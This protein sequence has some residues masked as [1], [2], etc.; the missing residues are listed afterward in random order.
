[1]RG[2][3]SGDWVVLES[4]ADAEE[5]RLIEGFLHSEGIDCEIESLRFNQEPVNLG[6]LSEIRLR[7]PETQIAEARAA[8]ER[9]RRETLDDL[10]ESDDD[11]PR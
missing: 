3:D 5:A 2:S 1:M 6:R 11:G 8:L 10:A 4:V 9:Q 7:V